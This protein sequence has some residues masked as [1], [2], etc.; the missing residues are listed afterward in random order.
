MDRTQRKEWRRHQ[1]RQ[2]AKRSREKRRQELKELHDEC[3]TLT[4]MNQTLVQQLKH[5]QHKN[6]QLKTL[7][8]A[9]PPPPPS[10]FP[11]ENQYFLH[12]EIDEPHLVFASK[13]LPIV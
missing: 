2:A 3:Q 10:P 9:P 13:I 1:N 8:S 12:H 7:L 4:H 6:Q 5:L 11:F